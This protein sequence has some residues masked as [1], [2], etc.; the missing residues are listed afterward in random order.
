[1]LVNN[2]NERHEKKADEKKG[3]KLRALYKP[4]CKFIALR[5]KCWAC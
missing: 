5:E 1:M 3:Q 2:R 4:G